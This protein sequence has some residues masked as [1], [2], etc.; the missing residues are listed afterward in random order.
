MPVRCTSIVNPPE[1]RVA[2]VRR[3]DAA[4]SVRYSRLIENTRADTLVVRRQGETTPLLQV[5]GSLQRLGIGTNPASDA[6]LTISPV[7]LPN[8]LLHASY[9]ASGDLGS[10]PSLYAMRFSVALNSAPASA[11]AGYG[12]A[13]QVT[14]GGGDGGNAITLYGVY[15]TAY[16]INMMKTWTAGKTHNLYGGYFGAGASNYAG[17]IPSNVNAYSGYFADP[18]VSASGTVVK[19]A[20]YFGGDIEL[21]D[22]KNL[23]VA[24]GTGTKLGTAAGQKLGF[25][26]VT[27]VTQRAAN[28][29]TAGASLGDLETEVNEIKQALRDVGIIAT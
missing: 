24:T 25:W 26:G 21:A 12:V 6:M 3:L 7:G 18:S 29:D 27:P 13:G 4:D 22:G 23:H 16:L 17:S 19:R 5:D 9:A 8:Y 11:A 28:T 20:A 1:G 14:A 10:F 15:A 2:V